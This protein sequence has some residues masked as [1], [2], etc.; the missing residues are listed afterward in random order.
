[1]NDLIKKELGGQENYMRKKP[2]VIW[3]SGV[4]YLYASEKFFKEDS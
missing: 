2:D 4:K 3:T 1:M